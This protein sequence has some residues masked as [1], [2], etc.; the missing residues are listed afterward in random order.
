LNISLKGRADLADDGYVGADTAAAQKAVGELVGHYQAKA[1]AV[2]RLG[3]AIGASAGVLVGAVP[4]SPLRFAWPI[5]SGYGF[6]TI[7]GGLIVGVLIGYVIG[8]S[9][10]QM[11]HRMAEQARLQLQLEQR[12]SD[13]DKRMAQLLT[14]LTARA[15]ASA[16]RAQTPQPVQA[17]QPVQPPQPVQVQQAQPVPVALPPVQIQEPA[18]SGPVAAPA[19]A[20]LLRPAAVAPPEQQEQQP[21]QFVQPPQPHLTQVPPVAPTPVAVPNNQSTLVAPPLSPPISG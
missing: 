20:Q 3:V 16:A 13:N 1:R 17:S 4:L 8:D 15:T 14:A 10:A 6:A 2:G 12:I 5:P 7:L 19:P 11:Y 18:V 9:R 21:V